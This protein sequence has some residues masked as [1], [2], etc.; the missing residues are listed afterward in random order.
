MDCAAQKCVAITFDD[1]PGPYTAKLLDILEQKKA[2]AT[3]F[4]IGKSIPAYSTVVARQ[5][6]LGM[7]QCNHTQTH[8]NLKQLS[9]AQQK[10]QIDQTQQQYAAAVPGGTLSCL[11]P[12]Y[13]SFN[14]DT[15]SLG[16]PLILWDVDTEDWKNKSAS[17]TTQRALAGAKGGSIILMHDIDPST[18]D[19][20]PGIIDQLRAK[21]FTLVT[22]D[23]LIG[24]GQPGTA[25]FSQHQSS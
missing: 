16:L 9:A 24:A 6:T 10:A 11:R 18:V 2:P 22:V 17:V 23:Q 13:G 20:V 3:F 7:Q 4:L 1:G 5:R 19:A 12:P 21:G 8:P 15:R 14:A 25:Y